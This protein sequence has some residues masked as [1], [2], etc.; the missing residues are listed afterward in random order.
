MSLITDSSPHQHGPQSLTALMLRVLV[1][2]VPAIAVYAMLINTAVLVQILLAVITAVVCEAVIIK[3]RGRAV[4]AV[5]TDLSAVLTAVLLALAIPPLAPWWIVVL[6]T[7]FAIIFGKQIFGGLGYNPFN[8]AMLGYAMLLISFPVEMTDWNTVGLYS[9]LFTEI[10]APDAISGATPL[11]SLKTQLTLTGSLPSYEV[12][13]NNWKGS[14]QWLNV[15]FL[16]GGLWLLW[17]RDIA[18]QIPLALL[19]TI[20][21]F[22]GVFWLIDPTQYASPL[23]H[24][25]GGATMLAAF[26]IATDPVSASTTPRGRLI[27]A[28]GI[29]III[30]VIRN[31]GGYPD[32]VAF[33][34]LL[35]NMA[36]PTIDHFTRPKVF[37]Q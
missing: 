35:M 27:Y 23:F 11:D 28:A 21:V 19:T 24:L 18:W 15:A 33:A 1:A 8:P 14:W 3:M 20:A 4:A 13:S 12:F 2:L 22:S 29:G 34:V 17:S 26:F 6:G 7:A 31:W 25:F 37:G 5:I 36:A 10:Q 9:Q 32:A 16:L 30:C